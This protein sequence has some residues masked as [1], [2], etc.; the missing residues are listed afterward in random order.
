MLR[1]AVSKL[2]PLPSWTLLLMRTI[3]F[4]ITHWDN[5]CEGVWGDEGKMKMA[6]LHA[7]IQWP[8]QVFQTAAVMEVTS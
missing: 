8:L 6:E 1:K 7:M 3:Q 4:T 2:S 5:L